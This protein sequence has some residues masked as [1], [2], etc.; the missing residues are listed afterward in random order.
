[1][2]GVRVQIAVGVRNFGQRVPGAAGLGV[3]LGV[4]IGACVEIGGRAFGVAAKKI[5]HAIRW[6]RPASS[7]QLHLEL[8]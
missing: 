3:A 7:L 4:E 5:D 6:V 8:A 2:V 1:M